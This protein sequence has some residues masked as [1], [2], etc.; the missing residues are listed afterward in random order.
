MDEQNTPREIA[1]NKAEES[2]LMVVCDAVTPST[3]AYTK[4]GLS[5]ADGDGAAK[6]LEQKGLIL[7]ERIVL[8]AGRGGHGMG[9]AAT[10]AGYARAGKER[11]VK[12]RGGDS[13]QHQYLV[14][15][16]SRLIPNSTV[17]AIVG[18]K[19]VDLLIAFNTE[20]DTDRRLITYLASKTSAALN[21]SSLLA[22]EVET[23]DPAKTAKNNI[24]KNHEAGIALTVVLVLPK[25]ELT[26][27]KA[28]AA[29]TGLPS[30]FVVLNVLDLLTA[31]GG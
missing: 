10:T 31:L 15:E 4:A 21:T 24:V 26:L 22:L 27:K 11:S 2:L 30:T 5:L 7:R 20:R 23:S 28:L 19:A 8:H 1:L 13:I 25:E 29:N 6:R 17:E 12:T 3:P 16:L 18:T 14:Q 9:L